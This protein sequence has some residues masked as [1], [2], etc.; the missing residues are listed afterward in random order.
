[1]KIVLV[2]VLAILLFVMAVLFGDQNH[3]NVNV[4]FIIAQIEM[5]LST[6]VALSVAFG[7]IVAS[8]LAFVTITRLKLSHML[9]SKAR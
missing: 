1:M 9:K 5:R 8:I 3:Q 2:S 7:F 6:L 4:S